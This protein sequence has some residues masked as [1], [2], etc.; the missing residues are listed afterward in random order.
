MATVSS[1]FLSAARA[2]GRLGCRAGGSRLR[3][4]PKPCATGA[5]LLLHHL[6]HAVARGPRLAPAEVKR[7]A[8]ERWPVC[9]SRSAGF[10]LLPPLPSQLQPPP[11]RA[12]EP[13]A[14]GGRG[15]CAIKGTD[16]A[17]SL[18][19]VQAQ[20]LVQQLCREARGGKEGRPWGMPDGGGSL[21]PPSG[22]RAAACLC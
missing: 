11:V 4:R 16:V 18:V 14:G 20:L 1:E 17:V 9:R 10:A 2:Q 21:R 15:V 13:L 3:L 22:A 5:L 6:F 12:V 7:N 8:W 19:L